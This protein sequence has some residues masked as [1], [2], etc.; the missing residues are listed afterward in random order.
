M[1]EVNQIFNQRYRIIKSIGQGGMGAVYLSED[2]LDHTKWAIKEELITEQNQRLLFSEAEIM[3]KVSHPAF[4][5]FRSKIELNGFLYIIMEYVEGTT[6]EAVIK[7]KG[8]IE[9]T[10]VIDWF[11]QACAAL[12]YLHGLETSVVYRDFKPSNIMLDTN[13]RIRI[14]DL[15]IAQEYRGDGAKAEIVVLTRGYAAPEQYDKRY[16]LDER[17]DIYAL[18]ATMHYMVTGKN[19]NTPPYVFEP[20]HKLQKNTSR[21]IEYILKKCLQPNPDKRYANAGLLLDDLNRIDEL[22]KQ[23]VSRMKR[24]RVTALSVLGLVI[25]AAVVVYAVNLNVQTKTIE[26]YYSYL[27]QA[28]EADTLED[29]L[30]AASL[31][32]DISPENPDAYIVYASLCIDYGTIDDAYAY[33]ND[34]VIVKFPEIYNNQDFLSLL[35][36]IEDYQ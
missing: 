36:K 10:K 19:P 17:T 26:K 21:A 5:A 14:I 23:L 35:Q 4:P 25:A 15:G 11:K 24:Q 22:Q 7:K 2:I 27:E 9:E 1:L 31:A 16:K 33:I 13:G 3:E 28:A 8:V 12:Q 30:S 34:V 20:T 18:A 32:I 29:A 6:L